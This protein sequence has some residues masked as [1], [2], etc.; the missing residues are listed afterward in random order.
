M[1]GSP[2]AISKKMLRE[3]EELLQTLEY[4]I[5][6]SDLI[7]NES[8]VGIHHSVGKYMKIFSYLFLFGGM[9]F[10]LNSCRSGY[11]SS[12]PVYTEYARPARPSET[13]IWVDGDWGWNRQ[14]QVYVQRPGYW[15]R[16]RQ[17]HTYVSGRWQT[18]PRGKYWTR[19]HWQKEYRQKDNRKNN[20]RNTDNR[21]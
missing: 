13:Y 7:A 16:P 4:S 12:E 19:G 6:V 15:E 5:M 9:A 14:S 18:S 2:K 20:Y 8:R 21:H 17:G 11:V 10:I 1:K 3:N